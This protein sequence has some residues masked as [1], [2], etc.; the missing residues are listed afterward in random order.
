M[1]AGVRLGFVAAAAFNLGGILLFTR[2]FTNRAIFE[3]DPAM[4]S[5]PACLL[6]MVW[7]LAYAA[8]S[9]SWRAAP[10]LSAVFALEKF[11]Y[12]AWWGAWLWNHGGELAVLAE[13]DRL[14][15]MFYGSYGAGDA[16]FGVFFAW[17][18][19]QARRR[20]RA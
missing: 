10:A 5:R 8:Q 1:D 3:T 20:A 11:I 2:A 18:A 16:V 19:W 14:A 7:G 17:A 6:V 13:R 9:R 4:F 15:G 12:A